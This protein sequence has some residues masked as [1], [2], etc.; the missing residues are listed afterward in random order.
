MVSALCQV[1]APNVFN[2]SAKQR[3]KIFCLIQSPSL[4]INCLSVKHVKLY[5]EKNSEGDIKGDS[6]N[7][8][9]GDA[10]KAVP[11]QDSRF[12]VPSSYSAGPDPKRASMPIS[13]GYMST[14]NVVVIIF[15]VLLSTGA[16]TVSSWL[17]WRSHKQQILDGLSWTQ[18]FFRM[19]QRNGE[20]DPS[21]K[22]ESRDMTAETLETHI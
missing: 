12:Y 5:T 22:V 21:A 3:I 4:S 17:L 18:R 19:D 7:T 8:T 13:S 10:L 2:T 14:V 11:F 6:K 1:L 20:I 9:I 15:F 16:I